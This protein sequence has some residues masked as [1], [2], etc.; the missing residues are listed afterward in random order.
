MKIS[1]I[2]LMLGFV[3][4]AACSA[5]RGVMPQVQTA[6]V[7]R[8]GRPLQAQTATIAHATSAN[9]K[10]YVANRSSDT[11]T[12][13][14]DA[15]SG[16][17]APLYHIRGG[18]TR[19]SAPTSLTFDGTGLM[20]VLSA[21]SF[22]V[23]AQHAR[24]NAAPMFDVG[25][26]L[27]QI[28]NPRGLAVDPTGKTYVTNY[29]GG[30]AYITAYAPGSNGDRAPVQTIIDG[31]S[32]LFVPAGIAVHGD[33]LYVADVGDQT[34]NEYS[35]SANGIVNPIAVITNLNDPQGV[36]IDAKGR[37]YVTDSDSVVVYAAKAHGPAI[38]IRKIT[39]SQ[40]M[41]DGV[42]GLTVHNSEIAVANSAD[43]SVTVYPQNGNGDIPPLREIAGPTTGLN[44]PQGIAVR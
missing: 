37:I 35:A 6:A 10:M 29:S 33:L 21:S 26:G 5:Q 39:G 12:V 19:L 3:A 2:C 17:A 40:T 22:A 11:V 28:S 4:L 7:D 13:Y 30:G 34:I 43:N 41:L 16:D 20:Y 15:A 8:E 23:F 31:Q 25:G 44:N 32:F 1:Q 38:P 36:A 14:A 24:G 42:A 18:N 27:T 9:L